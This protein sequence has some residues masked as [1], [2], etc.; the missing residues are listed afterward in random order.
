MGILIADS[1]NR[2]AFTPTAADSVTLAATVDG[3][4]VDFGTPTESDGV[5]N[6]TIASGDVPAPYSDV[7]LT[8]TITSGTQERSVTE[9]YDVVTDYP[10]TTPPI[11]LAV[12]KERLGITDTRDDETLWRTL[13]KAAAFVSRFVTVTFPKTT[14]VRHVWVDGGRVFAPELVTATAVA[15]LDGTAHTFIEEPYGAHVNLIL[16][17]CATGTLAIT[18]TWGYDRPPDDYIAAVEELATIHYRRAKL[19]D[20]RDYIGGLDTMPRGVMGYVNAL[21]QMVI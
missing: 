21:K 8:W 19:G 1:T 13:V 7:V 2:L 11:A 14:E 12:W 20:E 5:W 15:E 10:T 16:H 18:G 17:D 3:E 6:V 9:R 4:V